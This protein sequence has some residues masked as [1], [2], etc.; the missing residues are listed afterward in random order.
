MKLLI[1]LTNDFTVESLISPIS[2]LIRK[3]RFEHALLTARTVSRVSLPESNEINVKPFK[4]GRLAALVR[5]KERL[6]KE[7]VGVILQL[8]PPEPGQCNCLCL[9]AGVFDPMSPA[10]GPPKSD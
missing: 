6:E 7:R 8:S 3:A 4:V 5:V 1:S 9:L 10:A 2:S